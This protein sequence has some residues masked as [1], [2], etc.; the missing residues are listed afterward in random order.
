VHQRVAPHL[1]TC[2]HQK[3]QKRLRFFK[4]TI[5]LVP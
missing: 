2:G 3:C 4:A 5:W 1:E